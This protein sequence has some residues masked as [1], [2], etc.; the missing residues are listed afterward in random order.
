[1]Q[2]NQ[3][4]KLLEK[5][6]L[7]RQ[8]VNIDPHS[9]QEISDL[10]FDS[11]AVT[12][13]TVFFVKGQNFRTEFLLQA[14]TQGAILVVSENRYDLVDCPQLLVSDIRRAMALAA[15]EFFNYAYKAF[16]LIGIT[17]TKGKTTT[18]YYIKNVL[19]EYLSYSSAL[20]ST[21]EV[22][23][24]KRKEEAHLTTPEAIELHRLFREVADCGLGFLTME[25]TSQAYKTQRAYGIEFDTGLFLNIAED[26]ISPEEHEDF[27]DYLQ[28]KLEFIRN[29]RQVVINYETACF[30][31]VRQA[32]ENA[33]VIIT[34]G[35]A[36]NKGAVDYYVDNIAKVGDFWHFTVYGLDYQLNL[37]TKIAGRFNI[38]NALAAIVTC[39][40]YGIDD[41]CIQRGIAKTE[42]SGRMNVFEKAGITVIVDY[43]HNQLSFTKLYE[44]LE[45]DYPGSK[46]ITVAGGPGGKAYNRRRELGEIAGSYCQ[47][48]Y[49]TAEDPQF[50][51][52][53]AICQ[54]IAT[55]LSIPYEIII[56]RK[57]AIETAIS[58][59]QPGD[60]VVILG[61]GE[62]QYQKV[63]G[64][65]V[66]YESDLEIA[67]ELMK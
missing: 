10:T 43:A 35:S 23:T 64:E 41:A 16:K 28:C 18:S 53:T 26:H 3:L 25:V 42:V 65:F 38:E 59:A 5:E 44:S 60:V 22:D 47:F 51:A 45:L 31:E 39:R 50:E 14:L 48:M 46:I 55:Y 52:A 49:L 4:V 40:L 63:K 20:I 8:I 62:E 56:D 19:D 57:Q 54:E 15:R 34:Y 29:C 27:A 12:D 33:E 2:I 24:G 58:K 13:A 67:R 36:A 66:A 21:I 6:Q 9:S 37:Q 61:K 17:G 32:A 30:P 7:L 1:M 11:R